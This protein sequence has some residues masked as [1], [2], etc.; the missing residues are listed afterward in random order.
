MAPLASVLPLKKNKLGS[1]NLL[2]TEACLGTMTWGVQNTAAEAHAQLDY[3][4]KERGVN[5][6]DTAE[7]YPVPLNAPRA[8]PG[9]TEEIIGGWLAKNPA[10]RSRLVIATKVCGRSPNSRCAALRTVPPA[11]PCPDARLDAASIILAV[12]ASLRRLRTDYIDVYQLHFPDRY[13]PLWGKRAYE[14]RE[15]RE[16]VPFVETVRAI[17]QMIDTGKIRHWGLSNETTFGVCEFVKAADSIGCPRPVS[18]QNAVRFPHCVLSLYRVWAVLLTFCPL[19]QFCLLNRQ[20][21]GELAEACSPRNYDIGLLPWSVLGGGALTG[22]YLGRRDA[23][24]N[25]TDPSLAKARFTLFNDY[26]QRYINPAHT[27]IIKQYETVAKDAGMSLA[28]M[29]QKWCATR[30]YIPSTIIGGT[31]IEQLRENIDAFS[32]N[33]PDDVLMKIDRIHDSCKDPYVSDV[34]KR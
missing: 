10:L 5:F 31:T 32:V 4:I 3:A 27:G 15:E 6:L 1:S 22:K 14:P 21:E 29:A 19:R 28:T 2:V 33:L 30:W 34:K 7:N 18:I 16:A 12:E 11:D 26:Q 8:R 17:Q 13:S 24:G 25:T 23:F 20:F 9:V